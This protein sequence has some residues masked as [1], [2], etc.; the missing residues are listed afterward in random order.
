VDTIGGFLLWVVLM[1]ELNVAAYCRVG[2]NHD[3]QEASLEAQISYYK[4]L[5]SDH[6]G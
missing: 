3:E 4:K 5:I 1:S 2:T 6:E